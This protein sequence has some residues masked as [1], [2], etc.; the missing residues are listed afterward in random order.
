[1]L[2]ELGMDGSTVMLCPLDIPSDS[3]KH[4]PY[5]GH[6]LSTPTSPKSKPDQDPETKILHTG[7]AKG[8]PFISTQADLQWNGH[9]A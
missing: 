7:Q 8:Q 2:T 5:P 6:S 3:N 1:M 4:A 9:W